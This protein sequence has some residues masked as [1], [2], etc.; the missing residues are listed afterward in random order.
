MEG[1]HVFVEEVCVGRTTH[2]LVVGFQNIIQ[3]TKNGEARTI[4][5]EGIEGGLSG[6][7][8]DTG[9]VTELEW[10]QIKLPVQGR[11]LGLHEDGS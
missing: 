3:A 10:A 11:L 2:L 1:K 7:L 8:V 6:R 4:A 9:I 5:K